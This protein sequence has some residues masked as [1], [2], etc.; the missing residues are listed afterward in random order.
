MKDRFT[1]GTLS[2]RRKGREVLAPPPIVHPS[3]ETV[4][5]SHSHHHP[6]PVRV[7]PKEAPKPELS[8]TDKLKME[9]ARILDERS[10][11]PK[12]VPR[13]KLI[14]LGVGTAPDTTKEYADVL[15][16]LLGRK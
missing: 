7:V 11:A 1:C 13:S 3:R 16:M 5:H 12:P 6:L 14:G 10:K 15:A 4:I 2:D 9:V 8:E